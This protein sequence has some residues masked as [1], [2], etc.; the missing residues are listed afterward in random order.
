[1]GENDGRMLRCKKQSLHYLNRGG[2]RGKGKIY[3]QLFLN[4]AL[5]CTVF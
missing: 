1:M 3:F 4:T 5:A 2:Q